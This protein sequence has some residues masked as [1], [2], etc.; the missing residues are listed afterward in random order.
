MARPAGPPPA[1]RRSITEASPA[2]RSRHRCVSAAERVEHREHQR[3][4]P[5]RCAPA[6]AR[7]PRRRP[8]RSW[9]AGRTG[10][11]PPV[12]RARIGDD[13]DTG[14]PLVPQGGDAPPAQALGG[15]HDGQHRPAQRRQERGGTDASTQATRQQGGVQDDHRRIVAGAE[16]DAAAGAA[17]C[18]VTLGDNEFRDALDRDGGDQQHVPDHGGSVPAQQ[19]QLRAE[20]G[21]H[22]HQQA[23]GAALG[24]LGAGVAQD[25][26]HRRRRE[27]ADLGQR[28]PRQ[29]ERV[30]VEAERVVDGLDAPSGR[31]GATPMSR[32]RRSSGRGRPGTR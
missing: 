6:A 14:V 30:V 24:G 5:A 25:V 32:C 28:A 22:R 15:E 26:Q 3:G 19:H 29:L 13:D 16:L 10:T 21:A 20:A 8:P 11:G 18:Q 23:R 1:T 7:C 17:P 31:R 2:R 27:V 4:E 9:G 12:T